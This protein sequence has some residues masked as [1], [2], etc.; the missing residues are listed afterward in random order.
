MS[1]LQQSN[2]FMSH[3][4]FGATRL[5]HGDDSLPKPSSGE[6]REQQE[7][8]RCIAVDGEC[9]WFGPNPLGNGQLTITQTE[10]PRDHRKTN[11]IDP[12]ALNNITH[13]IPEDESTFES[14]IWTQGCMGEWMAPPTAWGK[15]LYPST[16]RRGNSEPPSLIEETE[17]RT[18]PTKPIGGHVTV[19]TDPPLIQ[20]DEN[21]SLNSSTSESLFYFTAE[22]SLSSLESYDYAE[23]AIAKAA[24]ARNLEALN[25]PYRP[26]EQQGKNIIF[27]TMIQCLSVLQTK[28]HKRREGK[29]PSVVVSP[30]LSECPR[31]YPRYNNSSRDERRSYATSCF[32]CQLQSASTVGSA[33]KTIELLRRCFFPRRDVIK[34]Q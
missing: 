31:Q 27:G 3:R 24:E 25:A 18:T 21:E 15:P 22:S 19:T 28:R 16:T 12:T 10:Q 26:E 33:I 30:T 13:H 17:E 32:Y 2:T 14:L 8:A 7:T 6:E 9:N 1:W 29:R 23:E 11:A 20:D 5:D 34:W 4:L